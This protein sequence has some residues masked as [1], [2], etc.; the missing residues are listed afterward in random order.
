MTL[1]LFIWRLNPPHIWHI[2]TIKKMLEDNSKIL[3]LLWTPFVQDENNPFNFCER[4]D[5]L[6]KIFKNN[7]NLEILELK[8]KKTDLEWIKNIKNILENNFSEFKKINFYWWDFENDSAFKVF[9]EYEEKFKNCT[10][11]YILNSRKNSF[12]EFERKKILISATNFR[13]ALKN[14]NYNLA[15]K[16]CNE[17]IFEDIKKEFNKKNLIK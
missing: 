15:K 14:K 16:F 17:I 13:E 9:K 8:D 7:S 4:S 5:I 12:I 3:I 1:W 6:I 10:F 2:Q 11:N